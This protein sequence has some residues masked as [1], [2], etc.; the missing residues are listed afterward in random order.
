MQSQSGPA[1]SIDYT[2]YNFT[3]VPSRLAFI[4]S[5]MFGIL[6]EGYDYYINGNGGMKGVIGKAIQLFNQTGAE[7]DEACL[8]TYLAEC[9]F[10]PT[11]ILQGYIF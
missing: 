7:M 4:D 6:F 3:N 11:S 2:H 9:F 8:V 1:L 10:I 5:S